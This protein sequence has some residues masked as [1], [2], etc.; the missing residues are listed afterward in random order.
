M[1]VADICFAGDW[2]SLS[3]TLYPVA[4]AGIDNNECMLRGTNLCILRGGFLAMRKRL[5]QA[6]LIRGHE[7]FHSTR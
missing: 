4:V 7:F 1:S 6:Y 5:V 3:L 2:K